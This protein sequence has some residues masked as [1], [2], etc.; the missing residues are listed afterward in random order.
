M[1]RGLWIGVALLIL[2][3]LVLTN[4]RQR[5]DDPTPTPLPEPEIYR[6]FPS[7]TAPD[8]INEITLEIPAEQL[9]IGIA[10][11]QQGKWYSMADVS[12]TIDSDSAEQAR[13]YAGLMPGLAQ[14][15]RG[16]MPVA[17][18]GFSPVP[19]YVVRF[20]LT[21]E[22]LVTVYIGSQTPSGGAYYVSDTPDGVIIDLVPADWI[23]DFIMLMRS[24][25]LPLAQP[26]VL[27]TA[28]P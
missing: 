12:V 15:V 20:G 26:D 8:Q 27:P 1:R 7:I 21:G 19:Q 25:A 4:R 13:E 11:D 10:I 5:A 16:D 17:T 6:L 2:L 18:L 24:F 14:V 28:T 23:D 3:V 9:V 22:S